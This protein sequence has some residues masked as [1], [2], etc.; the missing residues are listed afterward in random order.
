MASH[1]LRQPLS[2][3]QFGIEVLRTNGHDPAR[4]QRTLDAVDRNVK[5]L[6]EL[7]HKLESIARMQDGGDNPVVQE[8]AIGT[9]AQEAARQL[10]EMAEGR[11]V[12][13]QVN[14]DL[15][16]VTVDVGRLELI[17]LNLLSNGI[18]YSDPDKPVRTVQVTGQAADG[19]CRL[20][21][22]DNGVGIPAS[23][24]TT[25]FKRFTRL[26]SDHPETVKVSGLGL[27]LSIAD[28]CARTLGG[29]IEVESEEGSGTRFLVHFPVS[30]PTPHKA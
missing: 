29:R 1:E 5:L 6:A 13:I 14:D 26:H 7:T 10:R 22:Q 17:L 11:G 18:K 24:L 25:I 2:V 19:W 8:V 21:V 12:E 9:V 20:E 4:A 27:G 3:L 30:G 23:A 16:T 28:D 15:P